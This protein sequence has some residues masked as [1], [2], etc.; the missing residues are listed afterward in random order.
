MKDI[1][2]IGAGAIGAAV[3]RTLAQY[4][5]D[6]L[7]LEKESDVGEVTSSA[8]SAIVHSGY[9][10]IP[11][12]EKAIMNVR[13]NL[14][15]DQMCDELDIDMRKIGSLT[16]ATNDEEVAILRE[17]EERGKQ[18][19]VP[20]Q[21]LNREE[22]LA[23]EPNL[24]PEV[25]LALLAPTA[26][27]VNP[28]ELVIALMEN[29]VDNGC[30]LHCDEEVTDIRKVEGGYEIV[31][32][33][34]TYATRIVVNAA[35]LFSDIIN[36]FV[37]PTKFEI[38]PR[39]GEYFVLDHFDPNFIRH[40]IFTVPSSRGKGILVS[41]TTHGNYILGP[42]AEFVDR[43]D[44]Y[45]THAET[46]SQVMTTARKLVPTV[47]ANQIIRQFSGLRAV[48]KSGH[49]IIEESL[50]GFVNLVGIQSPG[51]TSCPAIALE[52]V[53]MVK[54]TLTLKKKENFNPRR[55]PVV[56]L[57]RM[58]DEE[59]Y[60]FVR[61][62][63]EFG[64]IICRCEKVSEGE[65]LDCIRRNVG[66]KTVRGVKRRV[67]PGMGKCQ[68]GFCQP[69][70]VKILARELGI[71]NEEVRMKSPNSWIMDAEMMPEE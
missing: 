54:K 60:A 13:G 28:F 56:R 61:E 64:N 40:T 3:A 70:I 26:G 16:I 19:G 29:A 52:V 34:E 8:N 68:G 2:I 37:N 1:I 33:R 6:I 58:N 25:K 65:V 41:P 55:R 47:P 5:L 4:D 9:D 36:N 38:Q 63:P 18:N 62:N 15:F 66:A 17:L 67:R 10:P 71:R 69:R 11:G 30:A 59:R 39:K 46:L 51:L 45:A 22:T 12:S 23:I 53:A 44:D 31:T 20:I 32:P 35:G 42:S 21:M 43:K 57:N 7:V 49:F 27:I 50:P 14:L 24:T 48:E